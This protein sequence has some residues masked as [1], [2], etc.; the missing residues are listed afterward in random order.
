M[1][2]LAVSNASQAEVQRRLSSSVSCSGESRC[3][4]RALG[5][6]ASSATRLDNPYP[7]RGKHAP[8][9]CYSLAHCAWSDTVLPS[10]QTAEALLLLMVALRIFIHLRSDLHHFNGD[11]LL[12]QFSAQP[13]SVHVSLDSDIFSQPPLRR[14][15]SQRPLAK[16]MP[17]VYTPLRHTVGT[18]DMSTG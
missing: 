12:A 6:A 5:G 4:F 13:D 18:Q 11:L 1:S 3:A 2:E 7:T 14:L 10:Q 15:Q 17:Q 9:S 16:V 8:R